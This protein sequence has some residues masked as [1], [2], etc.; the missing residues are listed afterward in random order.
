MGNTPPDD[1]PIYELKRDI[2]GKPSPRQ[3]K[4]ILKDPLGQDIELPHPPKSNCKVCYGKG[5]VGMD[6]KTKR[7][8]LCGKC[9]K[10]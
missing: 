3:S 10:I 4:F 2:T 1:K 8:F 9:Y 6:K 7:L 5:F